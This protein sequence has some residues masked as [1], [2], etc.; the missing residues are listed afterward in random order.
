MTA[1]KPWALLGAAALALSTSTSAATVNLF[2][3]AFNAHGLTLSMSRAGLFA[4]SIPMLRM[5][6]LAQRLKSLTPIPALPSSIR[7]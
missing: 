4:G 2:E 5:G 6:A 1:Y 7:K 3:Y